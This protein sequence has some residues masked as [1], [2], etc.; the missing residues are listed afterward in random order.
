MD[1]INSLPHKKQ[2]MMIKD[3]K[4]RLQIAN[5]KKHLKTFDKKIILSNFTIYIYSINYSI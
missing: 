1:S 3:R 5:M 4:M 2:F